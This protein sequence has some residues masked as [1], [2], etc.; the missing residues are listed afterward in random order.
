MRAIETEDR[1]LPYELGQS[2]YVPHEDRES[3][4]Y[5]NRSGLNERQVFNNVKNCDSYIRP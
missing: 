5:P 2:G 1:D 3:I 4:Q